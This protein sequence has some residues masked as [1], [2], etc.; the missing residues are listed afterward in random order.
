[1]CEQP[2]D[3]FFYSV[4]VLLLQHSEITFK[5][6]LDVASQELMIS[7]PSSRT[8]G[9][10]YGGILSNL[11]VDG[12]TRIFTDKATNH[13]IFFIDSASFHALT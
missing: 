2:R 5:R 1:M 6:P 10:T 13:T 9:K 3:S 4:I 8:R 11:W 12:N 7:S